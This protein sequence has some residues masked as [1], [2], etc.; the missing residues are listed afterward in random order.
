MART[1]RDEWSSRARLMLDCR[2][3]H[4]RN[5]TGLIADLAQ[6]QSSDEAADWSS[7][8]PAVK[9]TPA[10]VDAEFL[11]SRASAD[12]HGDRGVPTSAARKLVIHPATT[13]EGNGADGT[14]SG[15][16]DGEPF[17]AS[18]ERPSRWADNPALSSRCHV[19]I[20]GVAAKTIR[21]RDK[22]HCKFVATQP[23]VVC[24]RTPTK[25]ITFVL[26]NPR[27]WPQGRRRIHRPG[28]PAGPPRSAR[29][30]RQEASWWCRVNI[31][32][33]ADRA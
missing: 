8:K 14:A 3:N 20:N 30:R 19:T 16:F 24:G 18:S 28:L 6:L 7:Q 31:D 26:L 2:R 9:N 4:P 11:L 32:P 29:L 25:P 23:C 12:Q 17:V 15:G 1:E 22:E 10:A 33:H 13:K 5:A 27:S 21:L